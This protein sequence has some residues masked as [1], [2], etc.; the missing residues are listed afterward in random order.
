MRATGQA[1]N[2]TGPLTEDERRLVAARSI[3]GEWLGG[4]G[5]GWQDSGG[6]WPGIKLIRGVL[7]GEGDPEFGKSKGRLLPDHT[8]LEEKEVNNETR[9]KLQDSLVM[10]HGGMAQD[11]GPVLEMVTEKYLLRSE[12]EW[13]ARADAIKFFDEVVA[14]LKEGDIKSIGDFT[15]K[16]FTGPIRTII[17]WTTNI[18]T[19]SLIQIVEEEFGDEFWGFWM[20]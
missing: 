20:M 12:E 9:Q 4:S 17:P 7:A 19:E 5:G 13:K 8:I 18:Y 10:V 1:S 2:L 11:V 16:N 15:Q 3:L 14:K 6:V